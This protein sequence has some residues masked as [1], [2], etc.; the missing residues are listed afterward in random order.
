[1][2]FKVPWF[3]L[4]NEYSTIFAVLQINISNSEIVSFGLSSTFD[5]QLHIGPNTTSAA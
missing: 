1:M 2:L 5:G 3:L 4:E